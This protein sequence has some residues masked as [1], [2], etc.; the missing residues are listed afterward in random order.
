MHVAHQQPAEKRLYK[1]RVNFQKKRNRGGLLLSGA[2]SRPAVVKLV[3]LVPLASLSSTLNISG[4]MA[5][6]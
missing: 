4:R 2:T 5:G 1:L 3:D 6:K